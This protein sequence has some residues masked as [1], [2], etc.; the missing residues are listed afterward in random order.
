MSKFDRYMLSQLMVVFGFFS[1]VMVLVYWVN[2]AVLLFDQLISDGQTA[3]VFLEFT[4]LSLPNVIRLVL[5]MS[6]FAAAVYVTNRLASESELTVM[7]ATGYSP[8]RMARP[9]LIF[10]LIVAAMVA[11]LVNVVVPRSLTVLEERRDEISADVTARFL[12][13]GQFHHPTEGVTLF[14]RDVAA[15]GELRDAFLS[16]TSDSDR[17]QTYSASSARLIRSGGEPYLL[18]FDGMIQTL[19]VSGRTLSVTRFEEAT[20]AL[21]ALMAASSDGSRRIGE[22]STPELLW[23]SQAVMDE[24][25]RSLSRMLVEGHERISQATLTVVAALLGFAVLL[26]GGFSRFGI[27]RQVLA[28]VVLVILVKTAD[29]ALV[30][31]ALSDPALWPLVY[32]GSAA[33]LTLAAAVLWIAGR[34]LR[35]LVT[36]RAATA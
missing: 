15:G 25:G 36:R 8:F 11:A 1:L 3:W 10:G 33:G 19:D 29:T 34:P 31:L 18:M 20:Y 13:D 7:Q 32:G 2:R 23:P 27:W 14:V 28:A 21:S 24:V 22:L 5:P 26:V 9:V 35:P 4:M 12:R 6:A 16:D 17:H 30:D